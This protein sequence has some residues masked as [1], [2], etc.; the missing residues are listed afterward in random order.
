MRA[1]SYYIYLSFLLLCGGNHLYAN[2]H[3]T[4]AS[5]SFT[6]NLEKKEQVKHKNSRHHNVLKE[7]ADIEVDE[8]FHT[9]DEHND[10][11]ANKLLTGR[12]S[13][14]DSWYLTFSHKSLFKDFSNYFKIFA[15]FSVHSNPIYLRIGV[16]RI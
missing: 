16:F 6:Q 11:G 14:L 3:H 2:T 4:P 13:L 12:Q 15:P 10:N 7:S 9:N 1:I 5:F 8:E